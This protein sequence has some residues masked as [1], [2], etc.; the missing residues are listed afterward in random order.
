MINWHS[1]LLNCVPFPHYPIIFKSANVMPLADAQND[2]MGSQALLKLVLECKGNELV[3]HKCTYNPA[4]HILYYRKYSLVAVITISRLFICIICFY[5]G[6]WVDLFLTY[7]LIEDTFDLLSI[8]FEAF[9]FIV[10]ALC[11]DKSLTCSNK[12]FQSFVCSQTQLQDTCP[13]SCGLCCE[14]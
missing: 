14:L 11:V 4:T 7:S 1:K 2:F 5:S 6:V 13:R 12:T 8:H 9:F 3:S 10:D